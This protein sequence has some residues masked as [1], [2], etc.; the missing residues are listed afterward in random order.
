MPWLHRVENEAGTG[1]E[2]RVVPLENVSITPL[3]REI[4]VDADYQLICE[5]A[6]GPFLTLADL[7]QPFET[8]YAGWITFDY[9]KYARARLYKSADESPDGPRYYVDVR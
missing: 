6:S 1:P 2:V 9:A 5:T 8:D 4:W 3:C 7:A